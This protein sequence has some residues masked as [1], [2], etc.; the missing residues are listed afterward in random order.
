MQMFMID[1][2]YNTG[3]QLQAFLVSFV[4]E[5]APLGTFRAAMK[6][7]KEKQYAQI[8]HECLNAKFTPEHATMMGNAL[9]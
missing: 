9:K 6:I 4:K 8:I 1:A 5:H 2:T 7:N 3:A